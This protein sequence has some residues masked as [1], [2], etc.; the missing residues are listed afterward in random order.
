[1][2]KEIGERKSCFVAEKNRKKNREQ[3]SVK[4][5]TAKTEKLLIAALMTTQT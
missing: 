5:T 4:E 2:E 3:Y 1:M